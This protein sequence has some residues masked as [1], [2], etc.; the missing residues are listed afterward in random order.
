MTTAGHDN[1][2]MHG[3]YPL[4]VNDVWEHAYYLQHQSGRADYLRDWWFV[5]NWKEAGRRYEQGSLP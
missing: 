1:P 4:L 5:A 3:A 2:L